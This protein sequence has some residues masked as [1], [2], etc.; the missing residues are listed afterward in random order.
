MRKEE[1]DARGLR[2]LGPSGICVIRLVPTMVH[3]P[4][5]A[6]TKNQKR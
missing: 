5:Y 6:K 3:A 4:T 1:S 2:T